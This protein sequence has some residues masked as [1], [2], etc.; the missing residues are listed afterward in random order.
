MKYYLRVD[1][2]PSDGIYNQLTYFE[3]NK[4]MRSEL[5]DMVLVFHVFASKLPCLSQY[6]GLKGLGKDKIVRACSGRPRGVM[7]KI[8]CWKRTWPL[9][10]SFFV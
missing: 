9:S 6:C 3:K 4:S 2:C 5:Q 1:I 10:I 7:V 8:K